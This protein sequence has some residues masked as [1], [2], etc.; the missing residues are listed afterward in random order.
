MKA[1]YPDGAGNVVLHEIPEPELFPDAVLCRTTHSLVS[2]GT[3]RHQI[4]AAAGKSVDELVRSGLSLGY[5]GAGIVEQVSGDVRGLRPGDS[6]AFYGGPYARHAERVVMP[7]H[8]VL[9]IPEGLP[10]SEAAFIG[11][12]A[13]SLHGFHLGHLGLGDICLVS[14]A[15]IIG[16]LCAQL[17]LAAGCRVV[18]SDLQQQRL[19]LF[20][21]CVQVPG[22]YECV[23]AGGVKRA[24]EAMS[25]SR[26]ADGVLVCVA[27]SGSEPLEQAVRVVRRGG[28]IVLVGVCEVAMPREPLFYAEAEFV[29]ARAGGPGRYD[30]HYE[31]GGIDYPVQYARWTEGRNIEEVLRLLARGQLNVG[32]LIGTE[33]PIADACTAFARLMDGSADKALILKW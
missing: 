1:L 4:E 21:E 13:I 20:D 24:V 19:D 25:G 14:G 33:H 7:R 32:P 27:A 12:G 26:G 18:V 17:A 11:L 28:R 29:A 30:S 2:S 23:L 10:P 5:C 9:P 8:L 31:R 22:E 6:V 15:G 3:E 16:N